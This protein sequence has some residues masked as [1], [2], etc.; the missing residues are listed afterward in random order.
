MSPSTILDPTVIDASTLIPRQTSNVYMPIGIEG[1]A[2]SDGSAAIAVP[3]VVSRVDQARTWFG[4]ASRLT[5]LIQAVLDRGAGP[6]LAV[7]SSKGATPTL[8]QRKTAW[9]ILEA[10]VNTRIRLTGSTSQ[11]DLVA[12]A[13]SAS[14]ANLIFNKQIAFGGL[15]SGSS[16]A[17]MISAAG[18]ISPADA[19]RFV[20]VGP[21]VYD[22]SGVLQDGAYAAACV[23]AEVAKNS[24]PGNDLDL[25]GIPLLT[26][27][28]MD[29]SGRPVFMRR[30]TAGAAVDDFEDLLQG[31]VSPLQA[32]P[33][34]GGVMTTHLRTAYTVNTTYDNLY[35]RVIQD[36]VFLDVRDYVLNNNFLR[37]GNT[38]TTQ[39]RIKSGVEALLAERAAWILPVPQSDGTTGYAVTV[40]PSTDNRQVTIGYQGTVVRG[41]SSVQVAANLTIP[42]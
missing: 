28:E 17:A 15:A 10:D 22:A 9:E 40:T 8:A 6:V 31:G 3:F 25:W 20:L 1:Q 37:A 4:V 27:I 21:S 11:A 12:L 5:Q 7:A 32:S 35:T 33:V 14:N 41:I 34:A 19:S 38:S 16:K 36:Q 42:V 29:A 18:A 39:A 26:G 2:D 13:T 23:A 24:D 30:V